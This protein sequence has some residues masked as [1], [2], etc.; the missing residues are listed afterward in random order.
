MKKIIKIGK[1]AITN[2]SRP[3][4]IA[5]V[6][7]NHKQNLNSALKLIKQIKAA[8]ADAVKIQTYTEDSMTINSNRP[9]FKIKK[10][11]WKNFTLYQLYKKAKTPLK[12][13]KQ[14]FDYCKKI[15]ILCFST[16]FDEEC[17]D[18]LEQFNVPAYKI[19]SFEI[20]DLPFIK[21]VAKK[22]KPIIISTGMASLKE[23]SEAIAAVKSVKNKNLLLLHCVSKYPAQSKDY[24][25]KTMVELRNRFDLPLGLSDHTE[26]FITAT[27]ATALGAKIIEKHVKL[28][29]DNS[30]QDSKF[31]MKMKDFKVFCELIKKTHVSLGHIDFEKKNQKDSILHRRSIYVVKDIKKGEK[32]TKLNLKKIRPNKG[33]APKLF[34]KIV[35]KKSKMNISKNQPLKMNHIRF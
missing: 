1:F 23:I 15:N 22:N 7:S 11:L 9:E 14:I 12:W 18:F 31:S 34:F 8:G 6:S 28:N 16:P 27:T 29:D 35:G 20:T 10:G 30:S 5:E 19:A 26:D 33:L 4:I 13:H 17:S 25:L 21:H 2:N 24:N 3:F 32:F